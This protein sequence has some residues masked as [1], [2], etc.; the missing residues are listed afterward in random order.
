MLSHTHRHADGTW[1]MWP[2]QTNL[3]ETSA[4]L[5]CRWWQLEQGGG[6]GHSCMSGVVCSTCNTSYSS[7]ESSA[8]TPTWHSVCLLFWKCI[9][10]PDSASCC[11]ATPIRVWSL[12]RYR[13]SCIVCSTIPPL[14]ATWLLQV[15]HPIEKNKHIS[16]WN[17]ILQTVAIKQ[18]YLKTKT[19]WCFM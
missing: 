9:L 8:H 1:Q 11:T 15:T 10:T 6:E 18:R 4:S 16:K 5:D 14:T 7:Q 12:E 17:S 3:L 13:S 2:L 19:T